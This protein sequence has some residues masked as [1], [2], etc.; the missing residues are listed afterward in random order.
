M[1]ILWLDINSSYSHSSLAIPA[2]DAQLDRATREMHEWKIVSGYLKTDPDEIIQDIDCFAPE[3]ILT[4]LWLF[5]HAYVTSILK[6]IK[7]MRTDTRIFAGGPEFLGNNEDFLRRNPEFDAV[8]KGEGEDMF[9]RFIKDPSGFKEIGGFRFIDRQSGTYRDSPAQ[10]A[11]NFSALAPPESSEYFRW[12]KSFIQIETSRGCFNSC[13]FCISGIEKRE[14]QDIGLDSVK[15]RIAYAHSRGI[16]NIRILDRTFN[17]NPKRAIG[18]LGI[19]RDFSNDMTFHIEVHPAFV[20]EDFLECLESFPPGSIHIEAGIQSLDGHVISK[21]MRKGSAQRSLQGI[22]RL[23]ALGK[24]TLHTD[25]IA[26]LPGYSLKMLE[27]D[28]A[29][30]IR[31]NVGEIQLELLKLLPGTAFRNE[32]AG[33]GLKFSPLPPYEVLGSDCMGFQDLVTAKAYSKILDYWYN[34]PCWK[35]FFRH[36]VLQHPDIIGRL[37]A[38]LKRQ[39]AMSRA[40]SAESRAMIMHGMIKEHY[41]SLSAKLAVTWIM[42]GLSLK[43][44]AGTEIREWKMSASQTVE[45]PLFDAGDKEKHYFYIQDGMETHWFV[46]KK[47]INGGKPLEHFAG[48]SENKEN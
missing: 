3:M 38:A 35:D 23:A 17:A 46:T 44:G 31:M 40:L 32:H 43:K 14:I 2:L 28:M 45:N 12:D 8:F 37:A 5:N 27:N 47:N 13:A 26:G 25:L 33:Y 30:L 20:N 39:S 36:A 7:A 9:E 21:C 48:I 6:K 18:L 1:R 19:F 42:A 16:R 24:F 4:T 29:R 34:D 41:G 11:G 22:E 10:E 15:E